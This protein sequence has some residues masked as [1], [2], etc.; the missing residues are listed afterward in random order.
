MKMRR[1]M[2]MVMSPKNYKI[3]A[4][5]QPNWQTKLLLIA[6]TDAKPAIAER[7]LAVAKEK[8]IPVTYIML[9]RE[10]AIPKIYKRFQPKV[11]IP[12]DERAVQ[13]FEARYALNGQS[14]AFTNDYKVIVTRLDDDTL[15]QALRLARMPKFAVTRRQKLLRGLRYEM[16]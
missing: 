13:I 2:K 14:I 7:V 3:L 5:P 10:S 11:I 6:T 16:A 4:S 1:W 12:L 8:Q 15:K 9:E